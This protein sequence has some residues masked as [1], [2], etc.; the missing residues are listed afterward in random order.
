MG[1]NGGCRCF[2]ELISWDEKAGRWN[3]DEVGQV[4]HFVTMLAQELH[5]ARAEIKYLREHMENAGGD[6]WADA[7]GHEIRSYLRAILRGPKEE[8]P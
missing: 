3:R 4:R 1:T 8:T 6:A 2:E 5:T 7:E